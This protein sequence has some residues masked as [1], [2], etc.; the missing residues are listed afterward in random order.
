M[1]RP[2][3]PAE[4]MVAEPPVVAVVRRDEVVLQVA[5]DAA[6]S[7]GTTQWCPGVDAPALAPARTTS[8][9]LRV[10]W[11]Y[12]RFKARDRAPQAL[13]GLTWRDGAV[14]APDALEAQKCAWSRPAPLT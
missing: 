3:S 6:V 5:K 11:N 8:E 4:T 2:R 13:S 1:A 7:E 10:C 9:V 14:N 12:S